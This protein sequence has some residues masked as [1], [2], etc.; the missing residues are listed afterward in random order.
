MPPGASTFFE[1]FVLMVL[2]LEAVLTVT[3]PGTAHLGLRGAHAA[4][5]SPYREPLLRYSNKH[6]GVA[7][8]FFLSHLQRPP[9]RGLFMTLL[10]A[11]G[12]DPLRRELMASPQKLTAATFSL[13]TS[14]AAEASGPG[15]SASSAAIYGV[16][17]V[18]ALER[19]APGWLASSPTVFASLLE[20]WRSAGRRERL[21]RRSAAPRAPPRV[22]HPRVPPPHLRARAPRGGR[23]A[24]C[25]P[26]HLFRSDAV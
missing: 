22:P 7:V 25:A 11:E 13:A 24:L 16:L 23:G 3:A 10:R 6:A 5:T 8:D 20:V 26:V 9:L 1:P 17:I 18:D 2:R 19:E 4:S 14:P 21:K 15:G 12:A